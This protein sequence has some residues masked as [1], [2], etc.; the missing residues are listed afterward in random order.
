MTAWQSVRATR[1]KEEAVVNERKAV[2]AQASEIKLRELAQADEPWRLA[3][4]RVDQAALLV[5]ARRPAEAQ[6][7]L[8][9]ARAVVLEKSDANAQ[10]RLHEVAAQALAAQGQPG[11]AYEELRLSQEAARRRTEQL[12]ARQL[13]AQ[14]GRLEAERL[15]RENTLLRDQAHS[16]QLALAEVERAERLQRIALALGA[17]VVMG[18]LLAVWRQRS[19]TRRYAR[20]AQV[21]ALTGVLNRRNFLESGQRVMNRCLMDG[22]PCALLMLDVDRFKDINDRHGHVAGDHALAA[23][24]RVLRLCL[25]PQDLIGRYGGEEFAVIL[26]GADGGEAGRVAERLRES[27]E[28]LVPDWAPGASALTVSGGI[29]VAGHG[30][31]DLNALLLRADR[32]LY[33]AKDAGRNRMEHESLATA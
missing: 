7:L 25:R 16:S 19:L 4:L 22:R 31:A 8:A 23:V 18:A 3:N 33:R 21:D 14:R 30:T 26:P 17:T 20:L 28:A 10:A 11:A 5:Q 9:Q 29:A 1:A 13:A 15:A 24:A 32:A 27:V 2:A 6:A 12:V